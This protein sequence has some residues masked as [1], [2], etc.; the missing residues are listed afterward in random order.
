LLFAVS[1]GEIRTT[2]RLLN[3]GV[4]A[5]TGTKS[6]VAPIH[7][8]VIRKDHRCLELLLQH[9]ADVTGNRGAT[10]LVE[11]V[12]SQDKESARLLLQ[13]GADPDLR[14]TRYKRT[15]IEAAQKNKNK[16]IL[17]LLQAKVP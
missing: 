5:D 3:A 9:G 13:F 2:E 6:G 8:A 11:A 15:P 4:S 16:E 14:S 7:Y 1:H 12:E 10:T 17:V